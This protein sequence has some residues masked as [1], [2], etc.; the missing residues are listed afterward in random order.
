MVQP[1]LFSVIKILMSVSLNIR[2][3]E[4]SFGTI[5][6]LQRVDD[7]FSDPSRTFIKHH[8]FSLVLGVDTHMKT[9]SS[10]EHLVEAYG[11]EW[12]QFKDAL[13][14]MDQEAFASLLRHAKLHAEAG[15][16]VESPDL[17]E[18]IVMSI[19]VEHQKELQLLERQLLRPQTKTCPR[20]GRT[21]QIEEF[22]R[23]DTLGDGVTI[24]CQECREALYFVPSTAVEP[25]D[26]NL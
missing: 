10:L 21:S 17:F 5:T 2:L 7:T 26:A 4:H 1:C 23:G 19:L 20:C 22:F 3:L 16:K 14:A 6:I 24:L 18:S 9:M 25:A 12:E 13:D 11:L 8:R 15:S